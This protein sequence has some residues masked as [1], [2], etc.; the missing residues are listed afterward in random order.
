MR[1]GETMEIPMQGTFTSY[2]V[3]GHQSRHVPLNTGSVLDTY[4]TRPEAWKMLTWQVCQ[5]IRR[6]RYGR[7]QIIHGPKPM[8]K[9]KIHIL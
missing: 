9:M 4:L 8:M 3:G 7:R 6:H 2:H 5:F 1:M